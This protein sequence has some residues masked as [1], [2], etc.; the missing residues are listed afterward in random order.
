[1]TPLRHYAD[2]Y[3]EALAYKA[4]GLTPETRPEVIL[5][6]AMAVGHSFEDVSAVIQKA[7]RDIPRGP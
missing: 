4:M 6:H 2:R 7:V 5:A 3:R 1:M